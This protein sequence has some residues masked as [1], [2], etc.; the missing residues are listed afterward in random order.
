MGVYISILWP[1]SKSG[2]F[3]FYGPNHPLN[4]AK[5]PPNPPRTNQDIKNIDF[6]LL[7]L[8]NSLLGS[9]LGGFSRHTNCDLYAIFVYLEKAPKKAPSQ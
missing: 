2:R 4:A 7:D 8:Q 3:L 6:S 1:C 5:S 9:H